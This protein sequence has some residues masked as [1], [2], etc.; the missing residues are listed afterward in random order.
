MNTPTQQV[1]NIDYTRLI[2]C[3]LYEG[4]SV[5]VL[6]M[7]HNRGINEAYFY[8]VR[9]APIGRS[10]EVSGL[11]EI[12]KTEILHAVVSADQA[13]YIYEMIYEMAELD[14]P[15]RGVVYVNRL[16]RST[17][18]ELPDEATLSAA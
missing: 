14:Q 18:F 7:L 10:S 9:G 13:D 16:A 4:G 1:P 2:T 3:V 5:P 11:P 17:P 8:S 6:E 12:P 15:N